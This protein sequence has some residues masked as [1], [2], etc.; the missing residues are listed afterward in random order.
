MRVVNNTALYTRH[1][2]ERPRGT[3]LQWIIVHDPANDRASTAQVLRYL[4]KNAN[5][6]SYHEFI[7]RYTDHG[8]AS[9]V[10]APVNQWTGHA[11]VETRI[12]NTAVVGRAVNYNTYGVS[13]ETRG[14]SIATTDPEL[15]SAV[16]YRLAA[17]I[18]DCRLPDAG[19]I[20]GHREINTKR[21]RRADP[22]GIDM[23]ALRQDV[24]RVL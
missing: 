8:V 2:W 22:R 7:A 1:R 21:G 6:D 19:I 18:R 15:Y 9:V 5:G 17:L 11:G 10:L 13:V 20:L 4:Q 23:E 14:A 3:W 12:P 24:A 16:V